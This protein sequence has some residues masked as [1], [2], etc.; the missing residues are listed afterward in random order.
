MMILCYTVCFYLWY[1]P[2]LLFNWIYNNNEM[3]LTTIMINDANAID[4]YN[5]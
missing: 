3:L 1:M 5:G 4:K 2:F